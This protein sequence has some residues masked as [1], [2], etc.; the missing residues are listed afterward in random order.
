[1]PR[2]TR[3]LSAYTMG[4][5]ENKPYLCN[6]K[7]YIHFRLESRHKGETNTAYRVRV[8]EMALEA[9]GWGLPEPL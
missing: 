8:L 7:D 6:P 1:M 3:Q 2:T 4:F 9:V 5:K